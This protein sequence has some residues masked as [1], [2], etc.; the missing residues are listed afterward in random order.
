MSG[1]GHSL[2]SEI[3]PKF[4]G[5][6]TGPNARVYLDVV[7]WIER[8]MPA[9]GDAMERGE[10]LEIIDR[11][12]ASGAV[13]QADAEE[14]VHEAEAD[15][16]A[17]RILRRLITAGWISEEKRS[18]YRHIVTLEAA[19]QILLEAMRKI[20]SDNV[21]AFTGSLRLVCDRLEL[22]RYPHSRMELPWEELKS[23]L[24]EVRSGLRELLKIRKQVERYA[25]R[26]LKTVTIAEALDIIYNEFS[27]L[28][29][30]QCYRELIHA[31]LPE[32]LRQAMEGL[33]NLEQDDL[34]LQK[35]R[36][37]FIRTAPDATGAM[38]E[39]LR[40]IEELSLALG[41]VEPTADRVD[42][43]TAD[44]ARRSRSRI[45]YI[46]DVGSARRQQIK[47]I[48]DYVREH[49]AHVRLGDLEDKFSLPPIRLAEVGLVGNSSL[50]KSRK[51]TDAA[52]RRQVALPLSEEEKEESLREMEKNMRNALRLDRAN[53]FVD[54][55]ELK[56]GE[57]I[58]SDQM[59]IF[60][61][62]DILDVISCL[63]FAPAGGANYRLSTL[64][65]MHPEEPVV[66]DAKGEFEI[67]RFT[68]EKK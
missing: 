50:A 25:Q 29:T 4:F 52:A 26:Q 41:D 7:D 21:A 55:L 17:S 24:T 38:H 34:A 28:I 54:R 68:V 31:R 59:T 57:S 49:L 58:T 65:Q 23:C 47:T 15:H 61:E 60:A 3:S 8:E 64:R 40:T 32:R 44:F 37:D 6:L 14:E 35:L 62:D 42:T 63:V 51:P 67:E 30:Q 66:M 20:L 46:Q 43:S 12:L 5:V 33:T 16:P 56:R 27:T 36:D 19:A 48:F 1:L 10:M 45:R 22:L 39:I 53:R 13:L 2:F 9:R 11:V 18:D